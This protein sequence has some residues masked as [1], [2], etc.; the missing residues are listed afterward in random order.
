MN[1]N[2]TVI[3]P[4]HLL[5]DVTKQTLPIAIKSVEEQTTQ[6]DE[7]LLVVSTKEKD[8]LDFVKGLDFG[9]IKDK[10]RILENKGDDDFASQINLGVENTKTEWFTFVE[11]DDELSK[12][13]LT[14]GVKYITAYPEVSTFLP[15]IVNVNPDGA[16][17]GLMNEPVWANGFS[18]TM[19]YLDNS[20]LLA[21]QGF[22][23]DGMLMKKDVFIEQG[24]IKA[25]M[26]LS[27]IYEFLLR[28]TYSDVKVMVIPKIGYKHVN[29]R[30]N[31]LFDQYNKTM[32]VDETKWW[33][34]QAKK[35]YFF[36]KDRVLTFD[37]K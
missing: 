24:G 16:F 5:D 36:N 8:T 6:A 25:K 30:E 1:S 15:L 37:N 17:A 23:I 14:N 35:E 18:D 31:S 29:N 20:A 2:I 22:N 4:I 34:A 13:Y 9:T 3:I 7:L 21:Y 19:G 10:V 28:L 32:T 27:F 11:L 12:I 26:K 33:Y